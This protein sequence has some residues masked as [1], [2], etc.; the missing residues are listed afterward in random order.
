MTNVTEKTVAPK[1]VAITILDKKFV[2]GGEGT[3]RRASWDALATQKGR[4]TVTAYKANG[5][6][7]KYLARWAKAGAIQIAA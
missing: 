2:F 5:G 4:K 3:K 6:A 1:T 7:T